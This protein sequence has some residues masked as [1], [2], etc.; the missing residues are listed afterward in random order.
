MRFQ[1]NVCK[2]STS[3]IIRTSGT[4]MITSAAITSVIF[5]AVVGFYYK[6]SNILSFLVTAFTRG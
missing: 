3:R 1:P 4:K 6:D 5:S 2:S